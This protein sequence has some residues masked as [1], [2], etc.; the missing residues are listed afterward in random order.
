M[1][2]AAGQILNQRYRIDYLLGQ[3]GMGAVYQAWDSNLQKYCALKENQTL[4]IESTSQ[5]MRE[6]HMLAQLSHPN[7]P[8]VTDH[9]TI[10]QQGQY[11]VMEFVDGQDLQ[12][13][14]DQR[15]RLTEMEAVDY[16]SQVCDALAYLHAQPEPIIHRD[17][18]PANI[19]VTREGRAVLVDFGIAKQQERTKATTQGARAVTPGFSPPEQ[20]GYGR[21]DARTDIYALG[22]TLYTLLTGVELAESV[23]RFSLDALEPPQGCSPH[24]G[25]AV[26][27]GLELD[28]EQRFQTAVL[29]KSALQ[30]PNFESETASFW[31]RLPAAVKTGM[32]LIGVAVLATAVILTTN[33]TSPEPTPTVQIQTVVITSEPGEVIVEITSTPGPTETAVP[34]DEPTNTSEPTMTTEPT[35][36]NLPPSATPTPTATATRGN[37]PQ[38]F[39]IGRSRDE[40]PLTIYQ[41]GNG[42]RVVVLIGSIHSGYSPAGV[43]VAE[44]M[45]VYLTNVPDDVPDDV[46]VYILPD[47]SPDSSYAPGRKAGRLNAA[48]V[49]LNR[50]WSCNWQEQSMVTGLNE[51]VSGGTAPFSEPEVE[52]MRDFFFEVRPT[53]VLFFGARATNGL[54]YQSLC[55][56]EAGG[57]ASLATA[58]SRAS[59]YGTAPV[60]MGKGEAGD[61]LASQG[62]PS[63]FVLLKEY[64]SLPSSEWQRNLNGILSIIDSFGK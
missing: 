29:F 52:A 19:R 54:L 44:N 60:G 28:A 34:T 7:L 50:N 36:T 45:I 51:Y 35:A 61:W 47:A 14:L 10:P 64:D 43:D 21:T 12:Q 16:V 39:D 40:R 2:L 15:G 23:N 20:Y 9:F 25:R 58:Y 13:I 18:K 56:G 41:F 5:F 37:G 24:V 22:A 30:S 33:A 53:A 11:L 17:I 42:E 62:V 32:A 46:T 59:G 57:S 3:G 8:H 4:V 48:S 27:K 31:G 55:H 1:T 38:Q 49:D 26:L 6:A 63:I